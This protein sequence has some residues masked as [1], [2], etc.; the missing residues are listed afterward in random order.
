MHLQYKLTLQWSRS[1]NKMCVQQFFKEC[2]LILWNSWCR[3]RNW[4]VWMTFN[5]EITHL[6]KAFVTLWRMWMHAVTRVW[7]GSLIYFCHLRGQM[8]YL[9]TAWF[10]VIAE[11]KQPFHFRLQL[12]SF[13][14]PFVH[15]LLQSWQNAQ[16]RLIF[17]QLKLESLLMTVDL[18]TV[19]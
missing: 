12:F 3:R 8:C 1:H 4:C 5:M 19:G 17:A 15:H 2:T 7:R 13:S 9:E 10:P 16:K 11:L 6:H 18:I 14:A